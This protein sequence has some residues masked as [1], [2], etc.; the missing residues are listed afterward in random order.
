MES[1]HDWIIEN[2]TTHMKEKGVKI[3]NLA[4]HIGVSKGEF[5]K[6]LM[7]SVKIILSIYP[8]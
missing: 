3:E 4:E 7:G 6:I 1:Q 5:S 8:S 2:L